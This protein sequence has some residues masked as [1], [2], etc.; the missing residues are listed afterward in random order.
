[1]KRYTEEKMMIYNFDALSF[2]ILTI[3]RFY[4]QKGFTNVK[5]RPYAALSFRVN[6]TGDFKIG[7]KHLQVKQ[8]DVLFIPS[9]ASYEVE[10]S[11][12][13]SIVIHLQD[14][15]YEEAEAFCL[16]NPTEI[17][18]L[19]LQ[20]CKEWQENHSVNRAK[21]AVY[22]ILDKINHHH[23]AS[24]TNTAFAS[25][26]R[27][28]ESHFCDPALDMDRVCKEG[29][30]STSS[31]QRLF[32]RHFGLSPMQYVIK[33]RM[34]QALRLLVENKLSVKEVAALCG[35]SDE[36]YFSRSFKK[37]YGYPP[38]HLKDTVIF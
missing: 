8:G 20:L 11:V 12:S 9:G 18:L 28:I 38:S 15:N 33:L 25:C 2:Q 31:L 26:L 14:C 36:K 34:N 35:F 16:E 21:S 6:G 19:F 27:Y 32:L 7:N 37:R 30:I 5:A 4:H 23:N 3:D 24:I 17:S 1:M 22:D 10:Y 13:E 29:Y